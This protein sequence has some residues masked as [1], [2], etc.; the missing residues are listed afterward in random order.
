VTIDTATTI[1]TRPVAT[2]IRSHPLW[3]GLATIALTFKATQAMTPEPRIVATS[4]TSSKTT[5]NL[6]VATNSRTTPRS[7]GSDE[8][9]D[10]DHVA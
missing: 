8:G 1:Q 4:S 2:D 7:G 10:E 9:H 3:D 5:N 6:G